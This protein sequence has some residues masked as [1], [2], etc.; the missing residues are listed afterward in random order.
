MPDKHPRDGM[1]AKT[2]R[3]SSYLAV[4]AQN[5]HIGKRLLSYLRSLTVLMIMSHAFSGIFF[6]GCLCCEVLCLGKC[7]SA[8]FSVGAV[9][10]LN[11]LEQDFQRKIFKFREAH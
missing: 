2:L 3:R 6:P 1:V 9:F 4:S 5:Q 11:A 8:V 7:Q 10:H